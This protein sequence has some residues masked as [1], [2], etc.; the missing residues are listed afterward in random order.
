MSMNDIIGKVVSVTGNGEVGYGTAAD[1]ILG[2][3][4]KIEP[5]GTGVNEL[6][7]DGIKDGGTFTVDSTTLTALAI[8][9]GHVVTVNWN[10][11]FEGVVTNATAPL[12]G[13][14]LANDG[15]GKVITSATAT[16]V[17]ALSVD[18]TTKV[19]TVKIV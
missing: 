10:S 6:S 19:A 8:T 13:A 18:G 1:A 2:V 11:A 4:T 12:A 16:N 3:V 17:I 5:I 7:F 9:G 15:T 14:Y